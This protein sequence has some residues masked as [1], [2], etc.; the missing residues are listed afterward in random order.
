MLPFQK[1]AVSDLFL[2]RPLRDH[3]HY[4][5]YIREANIKL[6]FCKTYVAIDN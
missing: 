1:C 4:Y 6:I 2:L 3:P 5:K